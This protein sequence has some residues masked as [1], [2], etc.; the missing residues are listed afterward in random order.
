MRQSRAA[1]LAVGGMSLWA[2]TMSVP[3][4]AAPSGKKLTLNGKVASN[5]VQTVNGQAFVALADLAKALGMVMVKNADGNYE[6]KQAGGTYQAGD[7]SGKIGDVLFDGKWRLQ[8][9]S[10]QMPESF[11]MSTEAQPYGYDNVATYDA[12]TRIIK[13]QTGSKLVVIKVRVT[14]GQKTTQTLWTAISDKTMRTAL[15]DTAGGSHAPIDYDYAGAPNVTPPLLPGAALTF[16]IIFSVPQDTVLKDLVM[17]L[18]NNDSF[19]KGNDARVA[20]TP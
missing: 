17:T 18:K 5:N 16:P 19:A 15:T 14:N 1:L 13:P 8:V 2:V 4:G 6:I 3:V 12:K 10:V 9:L 7:L 11:P 20:L